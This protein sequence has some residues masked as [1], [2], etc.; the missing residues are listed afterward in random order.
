MCWAAARNT[1]CPSWDS[2]VNPPWSYICWVSLW[3]HCSCH[4]FLSRLSNRLGRA[5]SAIGRDNLCAQEAPCFRWPAWV[6]SRALER[7]KSS[8]RSWGQQNWWNGCP[9]TLKKGNFFPASP[10]LGIESHILCVF[11]K[12]ENHTDFYFRG[13]RFVFPANSAF[14]GL[15]T[16]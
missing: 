9:R 6:L 10:T 8:S 7:Y 12:E 1:S 4:S 16:Y 3:S 13:S 2:I 15:Q 11:F 14:K 5:N